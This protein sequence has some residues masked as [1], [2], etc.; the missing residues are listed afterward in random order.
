MSRY[1]LIRKIEHELEVP[2]DPTERYVYERDRWGIDQQSNQA[3][4]VTTYGEDPGDG[5]V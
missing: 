2:Q 1:D 5:A 4:D 3:S